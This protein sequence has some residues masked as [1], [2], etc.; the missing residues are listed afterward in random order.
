VYGFRYSI[1]VGNRANDGKC[2]A[3]GQAGSTPDMPIVVVA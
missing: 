3:Q 2:L 1:S